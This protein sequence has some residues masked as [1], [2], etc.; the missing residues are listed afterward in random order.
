MRRTRR[1]PGFSRRRRP[2]F[3]TVPAS[4]PRGTPS[5]FRT[6]YR[7][8][9]IQA[10]NSRGHLDRAF[11]VNTHL[12]A[13]RN[14]FKFLAQKGLAPEILLESLRY[15]KEPKLLPKE[16]L[17]H[18]EVLS[19]LQAIPGDTAIH[20]RDRAVLE[21]LYSTGIRRQELIDLALSDVDLEG[22]VLRIE[23]GKGQK[24]RMVPIGKEASGWLARYLT[25]A[26]PALLGK[27]EDAGRLFLSKSG[28]PLDGPAVLWMV[29]RWTKA[30][31]IVKSVS[32]H[33][34]RRSC[35]TG[36]IRNRANVAHVKDLLGHEDFG[37]M[38]SYIRLEIVD[39]KDAHRKFHPREQ[40]DGMAGAA[41]RK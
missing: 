40:D 38:K 19:I 36:M 29:R 31:G 25:S 30:A 13:L 15:V 9:R 2:L 37:S 10:V 4:S 33:T 12:L 35:A 20:L 34:F 8:F 17:T 39:L 26:R 7:R 28:G 16:T 5:S 11:T 24:G 22:G 23:S 41:L 14:F 18:P 3:G 32:P 1:S 21:V 27:R 6:R